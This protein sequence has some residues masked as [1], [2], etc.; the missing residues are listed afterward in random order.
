MTASG[1]PY[2]RISINK[3]LVEGGKVSLMRVFRDP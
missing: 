1:R 2:R 3:I